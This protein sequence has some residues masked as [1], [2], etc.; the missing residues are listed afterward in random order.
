M[1][2][3]LSAF[4]SPARGQGGKLRA[5]QGHQLPAQ[6]CCPRHLLF[7]DLEWAPHLLRAVSVSPLRGTP[8]CLTLQRPQVFQTPKAAPWEAALTKGAPRS[9]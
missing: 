4:A 3:G 7:W 6:S 8:D 9:G 2:E 5:D 1:S